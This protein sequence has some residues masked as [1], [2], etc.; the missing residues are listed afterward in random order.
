M[1]LLRVTTTA[2][3]DTTTA[4]VETVEPTTSAAMSTAAPPAT[5]PFRLFTYDSRD[6]TLSGGIGYCKL[7]QY[8]TSQTVFYMKFSPTS[9]LAPTFTINPTTGAVT[10]VSGLFNSPGETIG[11]TTLNGVL[12]TYYL[13]IAP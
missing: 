2:S 10:V 12:S 6:L 8:Q 3:E 1:V 7:E 5:P 4:S 9:A 13:K 11:A